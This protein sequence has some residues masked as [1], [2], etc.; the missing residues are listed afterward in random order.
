MK[1]IPNTDERKPDIGFKVFKL[2]ESNFKVWNMQIANVE[3]LEQQLLDFIDNVRPESTTEDMLYELILKSGLELNIVIEEK[4]ADVGK[5][6]RIGDGS[7]VICLADTLTKPLF[8]AI[9]KDKPEKIITLDRAFANN[10][11]L[12]TI[13]MLEAEH[14]G[15][16]EFKVI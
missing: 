12:K 8:E 3:Q 6:L 9:L 2:D 5:Y 15:V 16:K 14:G 4:Q 11:Q 13:M 1:F 10:D 7:L